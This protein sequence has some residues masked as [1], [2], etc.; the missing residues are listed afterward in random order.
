MPN[1][2]RGFSSIQYGT[3][4][5]AHATVEHL[6][7]ELHKL[8]LDTR[9]TRIAESE[10]TLRHYQDTMDELQRSIDMYWERSRKRQPQTGLYNWEGIYDKVKVYLVEVEEIPYDV[11]DYDSEGN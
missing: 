11:D 4:E 10:S 1:S 5:K 9:T 6:R 2:S 3:A 8:L 7:K